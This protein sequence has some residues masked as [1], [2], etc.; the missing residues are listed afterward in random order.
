V[1]CGRRT[2]RGGASVSRQLGGRRVLLV[3]TAARRTACSVGGPH[4]EGST[5]G[6]MSASYRPWLGA[7]E[8]TKVM[9]TWGMQR[10]ARDALPASPPRIVYSMWR[11]HPCR[12][13]TASGTAQSYSPGCGRNRPV[14]KVKSHMR[15]ASA[16]GKF[17]TAYRADRA[18]RWALWYC[19]CATTQPH[20]ARTGISAG[21][22]LLRTRH[23]SRV[24]ARTSA[25]L[26]GDTRMVYSVLIPLPH[27][28]LIARLGT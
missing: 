4:R 28:V 24:Q 7:G 26:T 11:D 6:T 15:G 14:Y 18:L 25:E 21:R 2:G 8:V 1:P 19:P 23:R 10:V 3:H 16:R 27:S 20:V 9:C 5:R 13:L 17:P 12:G 22:Q